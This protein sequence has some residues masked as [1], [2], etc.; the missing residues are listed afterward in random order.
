MAILRIPEAPK[1]R[2]DL[3][4]IRPDIAPFVLGILKVYGRNGSDSVIGFTRRLD[5]A[6]KQ[7]ITLIAALVDFGD[8]LP[9]DELAAIGR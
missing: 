3:I 2:R 4:L 1:D 9:A 5:P 6:E 8:K 7:P